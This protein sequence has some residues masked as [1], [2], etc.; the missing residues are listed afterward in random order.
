MHQPPNNIDNLEN[1]VNNGNISTTVLLD[2]IKIVKDHKM[3]ISDL[4]CDIMLN[5]GN[6][7]DKKFLIDKRLV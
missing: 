4:L 3:A 1:T 2:Y 5:H 7:K 6:E